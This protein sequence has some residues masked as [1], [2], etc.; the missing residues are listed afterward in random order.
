MPTGTDFLKDTQHLYF[1]ISRRHVLPY[2][3]LL[4]LGIAFSV[5]LFREDI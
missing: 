1:V 2:G 3:T 4:E 5:L